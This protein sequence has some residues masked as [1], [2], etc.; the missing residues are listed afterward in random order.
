MSNWL[1]ER[2]NTLQ[3]IEQKIKLGG[4]HKRIASEHKKGKLT[5]RERIARLLDNE[6]DYINLKKMSYDG[7]LPNIP[8]RDQHIR[9]RPQGR[10]GKGLSRVAR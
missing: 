2:W 3:E 6:E 4:G 9:R 8:W 7:R 1:T 10:I 5:A